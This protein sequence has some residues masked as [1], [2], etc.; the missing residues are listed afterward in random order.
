[1]K[2]SGFFIRL[3]PVFFFT[4]IVTG[5]FAQ[6]LSKVKAW[7]SKEVT[8]IT[9]DRL[10]NFFV[11]LKKGGIKKY[12]PDGKVLAS[13][14]KGAGEVVEPF[15]QPSIFIYH[16]NK[17][18]YVVYGRNFDNAREYSIEPALAIEP[19]LLIPT[20]DNKLW[21]LDKA[22]YSL[23]KINPAT[24]EVTHEFILPTE[25]TASPD[26]TYLR[27]YQNF[28]FLLD[29]NSG[30]WI[31]NTFGKLIRHI[32]IPQ[33]RNFNFFGEELYYLDGNVIRFYDLITEE[34]RTL[35]IPDNV[36]FALVTDE[37]ILLAGK[38]TLTLYQYPG[39]KTN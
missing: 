33:P 25:V 37:R 4:L 2:R 3:L 34:T 9:V 38:T 35:A 19:Y 18:Q 13:L 29:K 31:L 21:L 26:F 32:T 23:K 10:G 15:Y 1:M 11:I 6:E 24:Q 8:G 27:E 22:D 7:K 16:R 14:S 28:L 5:S 39:E 20:H 12:D 17:Q 36:N 30:I